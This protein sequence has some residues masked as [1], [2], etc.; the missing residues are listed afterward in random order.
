M[1]V[2]EAVGID[3]LIYA[4]ERAQERARQEGWPVLT[5]LTE[6]APIL[7][8]LAAYAAAATNIE[9]SLWFQPSRQF[10]LVGVGVA[11]G[12]EA[13]DLERFESTR[14]VRRGLLNGAIVESSVNNDRGT[15][16]VLLGA[17]SFDPRRVSTEEWHGFP[18]ARLIL[19]RL[20]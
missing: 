16:P 20:V 18:A 4:L 12:I 13:R 6:P 3:R 11:Q 7:D 5:S 15:G 14:H 8:P 1:H 10:A 2:D 17:F 19:P 9:R